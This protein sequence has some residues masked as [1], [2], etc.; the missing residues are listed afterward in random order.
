MKL[1][2][3]GLFGILWRSHNSS[4][5]CLFADRILNS[6]KKTKY[7]SNAM[8][9]ISEAPDGRLILKIYFECLL[10]LL[11][12]SGQPVYYLGVGFEGHLMCFRS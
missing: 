2:L 3:M 10:H 9:Y 6:V 4:S 12:L 7:H 1:Q 5:M 11:W 8:L